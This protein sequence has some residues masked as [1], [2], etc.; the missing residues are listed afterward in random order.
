M[1]QVRIEKSKLIGA[2]NIVSKVNKKINFYFNH[3]GCFIQ[4][5][6]EKHSNEVVVVKLTDDILEIKPFSIGCENVLDIV[7]SIQSDNITLMFTDTILE[8]SDD[9]KKYELI[10]IP[11]PILFNLDVENDTLS[12]LNMDH[13][14]QY[15]P[16]FKSVYNKGDTTLNGFVLR[17]NN[18]I[19]T[20]SRRLYKVR[21]PQTYLFN[22]EIYVSDI[23]DIFKGDVQYATNK[24]KLIIMQDDSF[25]KITLLENTFPK[26]IESFFD[27]YEDHI[28]VKQD[29]LDL[30][31]NALLIDADNKTDNTYHI[32]LKIKENEISLTRSNTIGGFYTTYKGEG[33][34]SDLTI[35]VDGLFLKHA[36]EFFNAFSSEVK[37]YYK[38]SDQALYLVAPDKEIEVL[39]MPLRLHPH[40]DSEN[41]K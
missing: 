22:P 41:S 30:I 31:S 11:D 3:K 7:K 25:Y 27:G 34:N 21:L 4:T 33:T 13:I 39:L 18:I 10:L 16:F 15:I 1:N 26:D 32:I 9:K 5:D 40:E 23:K 12:Q 6:L 2:L 24:D 35:K 38:T 19:C 37:I 20:D 36:L 17:G 14:L 29:F 8:I 28:I